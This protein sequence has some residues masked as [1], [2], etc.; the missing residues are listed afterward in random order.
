MMQS[1]L[2]CHYSTSFCERSMHLWPLFGCH[3]CE[4]RCMGT[5]RLSCRTAAQQTVPSGEI[6]ETTLLCSSTLPHRSLSVPNKTPMRL[7]LRQAP[8]RER[9]RQISDDASSRPRPSPLFRRQA[10][11]RLTSNLRYNFNAVRPAVSLTE[12]QSVHPCLISCGQPVI[13]L[14]SVSRL[15]L[16]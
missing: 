9:R 2:I 7:L 4:E 11:R 6:V 14:A 5:C 1:L 15:L 8:L 13:S 3:L 10:M 12:K 16:P